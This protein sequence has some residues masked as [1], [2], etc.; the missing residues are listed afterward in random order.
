MPPATRI[1]SHNCLKH[2]QEHKRELERGQDAGIETLARTLPLQ[3]QAVPTQT[4]P[5]A[6]TDMRSDKSW[7]RRARAEAL[8]T[9]A[10]WGTGMD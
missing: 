6:T 9:G 2:G 5:P 3:K 1:R 4:L 10:R 8:G 7:Q